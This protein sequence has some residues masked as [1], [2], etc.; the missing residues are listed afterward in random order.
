M[1]DVGPPNLQV[2]RFESSIREALPFKG[3]PEFLNQWIEWIDF[4]IR[5]GHDF[6]LG[7]GDWPT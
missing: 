5:S 1:L 4:W 3:I 2:Q 6:T 7:L